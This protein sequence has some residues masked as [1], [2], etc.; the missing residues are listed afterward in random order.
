MLIQGFWHGERLSAIERLSIRSF[1]HHGHQYRLYGYSKPEGL[2][3]GAEFCLAGDVLPESHLFIHSRGDEAGSVASFA[4][5]FRYE[6][7]LR[8]G[9]WW[10]DCDMVC[11][12][13]LPAGIKTIVLAS[14]RDGNITVPTNSAIFVPEAGNHLIDELAWH[15][16]DRIS[17]SGS[18]AIK[19]GDFGPKL[20]YRRVREW[21]NDLVTVATPEQFCPLPYRRFHELID[22]ACELPAVNFTTTIHLWGEMW[23]RRGLNKDFDFP[24][25][26]PIEKLKAR[27]P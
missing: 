10:F 17:S 7:L 2:P 8:N 6:L 27:Y 15:C 11:V 18:A 14:E 25:N 21:G 9:G 26:S 13:P 16:R 4:D 12:G 22:P 19:F 1:L 24:A 20:L 3:E 23:R 5:W